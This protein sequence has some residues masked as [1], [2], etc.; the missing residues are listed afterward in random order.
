MTALSSRNVS[1]PWLKS[2]MMSRLGPSS[3]ALKTK[4]SLLAPP[5]SVSMPAPPISVSLPMPPRQSVVADAAGERVVE[6]VAGDGVGEVVADADERGRDIDQR[7][8]LDG[9]EGAM[10]RLIVEVTV[11]TPPVSTMASA[12]FSST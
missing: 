1:A 7:Q 11:S 12:P 2:A 6:I 10:L 9:R 4:K 8:V 5:I 3:G